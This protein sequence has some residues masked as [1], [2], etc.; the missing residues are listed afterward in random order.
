MSKRAPIDLTNTSQ[1]RDVAAFSTQTEARRFSLACGWQGSDTKLVR[2]RFQELW[3]VGQEVQG[4][5]VLLKK[6]KAT[7]EVPWD[8]TFI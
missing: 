5:L 2:F 1:P 7:T 3:V 8:G 6:D 4:A